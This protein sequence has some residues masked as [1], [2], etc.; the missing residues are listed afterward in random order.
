M[1]L[2]K[3]VTSEPYLIVELANA[4]G[5]SE[6][7]IKDTISQFGSI[8]YRKKGIKFQIL[9]PEK[10][11]LPDFEW[12]SVYEKLYFP[13]DVWKKLIFDASLHGDVWVDVF[14]TYSVDIISENLDLV[15]GM[16][17][18]ASVLDNEE[19]FQALL[20]LS[21]EDKYITINIAGHELSH[22]YAV[23]EKFH[24]LSKN[25]ILQVGFQAYPT[26]IE[27]TG[28]QKIAV[29]RAAFPDIPLC[30]ADHVDAESDVA[31][32]LPLYACVLGCHYIEKHFCLSRKEAPY[33]AYSSLELSEIQ[34]MC[35]QMEQ[36]L[37]A[38]QGD[39]ICDAER[40]YLESSLQRPIAKHNILAGSLVAAS[41]M[42][43]RRTAQRGLTAL[44]IQHMQRRHMVLDVTEAA[45]KTVSLQDFRNAN[46]TI[47]V[48]ARMKSTRLPKKALLPISGVS[49][50]QRC[51]LQCHGVRGIRDVILATSD[52]PEDAVLKEHIAGS[53]T[54][55][56]QGDPEDVVSRYLGACKFYD[57]DVVLRV[58]GDCPL[59]LPEIAEYL[60]DK[61]FEAGADYTAAKDFAVGSSFEIFNV[62]ALQ[63]IANH[64]KTAEFSEYMTWYF[65]NNPDFFKLNIVDLP[66]E[67][68]RNYRITLDYPEDLEMFEM[69]FDKLDS[70]QDF[71]TA[72]AVFSVLDENPEI[73]NVNKNCT[74]RYRDDQSLIDELNKKTRIKLPKAELC[75]A[76]CT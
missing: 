75:D 35:S 76:A 21:L 44:E 13:R 54:K 64:F 70:E 36:L 9:S 30:M 7:L 17:L 68:I 20:K 74:L 16:K 55:F 22:I 63:K 52:L 62:T 11:A 48:A 46:I 5:G 2:P 51:L 34:Y 25:L 50:I 41:D 43:Y 66:P 29:L 47:I 24:A 28:L 38:Q 39:F 65:Q 53:S 45:G 69:L 73:T 37:K 14:D 40:K 6:Q 67:L 26:P 23:V 4:H 60:L 12:F 18:Q 59:V 19:V 1:V 57:I 49:S 58:T 15:F 10:I 61:H 8:D 72:G 42:L 27:S 3:R 31:T 32:Q 71:Y 33:D 56:W